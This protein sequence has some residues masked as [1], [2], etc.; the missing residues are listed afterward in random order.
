MVK[1][2]QK[3]VDT[4]TAGGIRARRGYP[5]DTFIRPEEPVA[6]VTLHAA[7]GGEITL[8]VEL[9]A[10]NATQC[11]NKAWAAMELLVPLG[12][13]CTA[14]RCRFQ[15]TMGLFSLEVL[16]SWEEETVEMPEE[17]PQAPA[18]SV[19]LDESALPYLT[20][21]TAT[22]ETELLPFE[23][24]NGQEILCEDE[25][26]ILT[27]EELLPSAHP[28]VADSELPFSLVVTRE[29]GTERFT[30]CRWESVKCTL[31]PQGIHQ[32]RVAKTWEKRTLS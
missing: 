19:S 20:G 30:G 21:F 14:G 32:V 4:L 3:V 7:A 23:G 16:V 2:I 28:P 8:A 11:E 1:T 6:A 31:T 9:Y 26:W 22:Y 25:V 13:V 12:A 29:G 5:P 27:V 17:L 15:R 24:E 18:Y 10:Q